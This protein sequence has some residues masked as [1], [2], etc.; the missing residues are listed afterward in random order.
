MGLS[1]AEID[2]VDQS[3][4][5]R[6]VNLGN[7]HKWALEESQYYACRAICATHMGIGG[8]KLADLDDDEGFK[9]NAMTT[10]LQAQQMGL[11]PKV[12]ISK[13]MRDKE[14]YSS[15]MSKLRNRKKA[16]QQVYQPVYIEE[17]QEA[18]VEYNKN[19]YEV[20]KAMFSNASRV[21][22]TGEQYKKLIGKIFETPGGIKFTSEEI[23]TQ[24][25]ASMTM[26]DGDDSDGE[27]V[28]EDPLTAEQLAQLQAQQQDLNN[29]GNV[30]KMGILGG[31]LASV[32][33]KIGNFLVGGLKKLN[34]HVFVPGS[35]GRPI[36]FLSMIF[37]LWHGSQ[38]LLEYQGYMGTPDGGASEGYYSWLTRGFWGNVARVP[39]NTN[40]FDASGLS[41]QYTMF[42]E[43]FW[44]KTSELGKVWN[45]VADDE[46][47]KLRDF[48]NTAGYKNGHLN[49][50]TETGVT[51][52][53]TM[54]R[55]AMKQEE[56]GLAATHF[57]K[58][59]EQ[60]NNDTEKMMEIF[61]DAR[62]QLKSLQEAGKLQTKLT[63]GEG[64]KFG[65]GQNIENPFKKTLD[66][67]R[68]AQPDK[69]GSGGTAKEAQFA[70]ENQRQLSWDVLITSLV[71][72][73]LRTAL[74]VS[75]VSEAVRAGLETKVKGWLGSFGLVA[76]MDVFEKQGKLL[77]AANLKVK[78]YAYFD[79]TIAIT[80][81][82]TAYSLYNT[83][84]AF[85]SMYDTWH[86][87][88]AGR[89]ILKA[90]SFLSNLTL[91]CSSMY[92]LY[93][94]LTVSPVY[95]LD[96]GITPLYVATRYGY[97]VMS[98]WAEEAAMWSAGYRDM[99]GSQLT[100]QKGLA[101]TCTGILMTY[102]SNAETPFG[103]TLGH[104][105]Q[106]SMFT[107]MSLQTYQAFSP[108]VEERVLKPVSAVF[109][110]AYR[111]GLGIPEGTVNGGFGLVDGFGSL[112][113]NM[114]LK[115]D[116]DYKPSTYVDLTN[117][118][119]TQSQFLGA[120]AGQ[121]AG[122]Q[123]GNGATPP[124]GPFGPGTPVDPS[125]ETA[126]QRIAR[127]TQQAR[128]DMDAVFGLNQTPVQQAPAQ[129]APLNQRDQMFSDQ[130]E[131]LRQA[132]EGE[133]PTGP[134]LFR[135]VADNT[136][137]RAELLK[138]NMEAALSNQ[139]PSKNPLLNQMFGNSTQQT[140]TPQQY[141]QAQIQQNPMN[142]DAQRGGHTAE[143]RY[144]VLQQRLAEIQNKYST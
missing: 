135:T 105:M 44:D 86:R 130:A 18:E 68:D 80:F 70:M 13:R 87:D 9:T 118:N 41:E 101:L 140:M 142:S 49:T 54:M 37:M 84:R 60:S 69:E 51:D 111:T 38:K 33:G 136:S 103:F 28:A 117:Q 71:F 50:L 72:S 14:N 26:A 127:Q 67:F 89:R 1:Q 65:G 20:Y 43:S 108:I 52:V 97:T 114:I 34:D 40:V 141:Q 96:T 81:T 131:R 123:A 107:A 3:L 128:Q 30:E 10:A 45:L 64:S 63:L 119:P 91:L 109:K 57:R 32:P 61:K 92:M 90:Y 132:R 125:Q 85:G 36:I 138:R 104:V 139:N 129:Q 2:K 88:N 133:W 93:G 143:E 106:V 99:T 39:I 78:Q 66:A 98:L 73:L 17:K 113:T 56:D 29:R 35:S 94:L 5:L 4:I 12:I 137:R 58:I 6:T 134:T 74:S 82:V 8:T 95:I 79:A 19:A 126:D 102:A 122:Q 42:V 115:V 83:V 100:Y 112:L 48:M 23:I 22:I 144:A 62:K 15:G 120:M 75:G 116:P 76:N 21:R 27:T 46:Y 77:A 53:N 31:K 124:S 59:A 24:G 11:N 16:K 55:W 47:T 7:G 121:Q 110:R 25:L